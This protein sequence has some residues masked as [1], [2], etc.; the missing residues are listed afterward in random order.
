METFDSEC[1][2]PQ[3][4]ERCSAS[5]T[6]KLFKTQNDKINKCVKD[7]Y[8]PVNKSAINPALNENKILER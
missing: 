8:I 7:S 2:I 6:N 1:T 4:Y 5:I 3:G